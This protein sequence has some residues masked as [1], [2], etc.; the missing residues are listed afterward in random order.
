MP[1][2]ESDHFV[3]AQEWCGDL[4]ACIAHLKTQIRDF[5]KLFQ[6]VV[7][8]SN[9]SEKDDTVAYAE[10]TTAFCRRSAQDLMRTIEVS[11]KAL[12]LCS[13]IYPQIFRIEGEW[14]D[15]FREMKDSLFRRSIAGLFVRDR[16]A[17]RAAINQAEER[18]AFAFFSFKKM[19]S[20][21]IDRVDLF[22]LEGKCV[23]QQ[24][25]V[26][27]QQ[28]A[29]HAGCCSKVIKK[30]L[31]QCKPVVESKGRNRGHQWRYS[32][33]I[34]V[35][36]KVETGILK[37]IDWPDSA[38]KLIRQKDSSKIPPKNMRR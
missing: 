12:P 7:Y 21:L 30:A 17:K 4:A 15:V 25:T 38:S 13:V 32:E 36:K 20:T 35:L 16:V 22:M 28:L 23:K 24:D 19:I 2:Q 9:S 27:A 37:G 34:S 26:R 11:S 5:E 6:I 1:R 33:A 29:D 10:H 14:N 8:Q 31:L 18:L 3:L